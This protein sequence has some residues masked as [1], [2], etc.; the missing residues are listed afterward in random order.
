MQVTFR[1]SNIYVT[2][3]FHLKITA[4]SLVYSKQKATLFIP[5]VRLIAENVLK[6]T[7]ARKTK[8]SHA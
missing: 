1:P 6:I 4:D 2:I 8:V 3:R 7:I 5:P